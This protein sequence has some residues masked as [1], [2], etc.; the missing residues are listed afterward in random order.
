[1]A[2]NLGGKKSPLNPASSMSNKAAMYASKTSMYGKPMMNG[3]PGDEKN[4]RREPT[5]QE[6]ED[7]SKGMA[8]LNAKR[9]QAAKAEAAARQRAGRKGSTPKSVAREMELKKQLTAKGVKQSE[10]NKYNLGDFKQYQSLGR[11]Y[12]IDLDDISDNVSKSM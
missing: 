7:T 2:Y 9:T 3:G 6:I 5:K 8:A 4:K 11:K 12:G 1:M 10:I